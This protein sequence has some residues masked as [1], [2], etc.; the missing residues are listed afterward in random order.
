MIFRAFCKRFSVSETIVVV[1]KLPLLFGETCNDKFFCKIFLSQFHFM[2]SWVHFVYKMYDTKEINWRKVWVMEFICYSK[3][4][5][6]WF[7]FA[8]VRFLFKFSYYFGNSEFW[9]KFPN[10]PIEF[11][12]NIHSGQT[13]EFIQLLNIWTTTGFLNLQCLDSLWQINLTKIF[14]LFHFELKTEICFFSFHWCIWPKFWR[15]SRY[16]KKN[17][18][19][20]LKFIG[21]YLSRLIFFRLDIYYHFRIVHYVNTL[22]HGL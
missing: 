10:F 15:I 18:S 19:T 9:W 3:K 22:N 7:R 2:T 5:L 16:W 8:L 13:S 1:L 14:F 4:L 20:D 6:I 21:R 11:W 12:C 17:L